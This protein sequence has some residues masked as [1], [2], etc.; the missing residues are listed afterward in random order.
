MLLF[1]LVGNH[2]LFVCLLNTSFQGYLNTM[3]GLKE[4][5]V[6][7]ILHGSVYCLWLFMKLCDK[8]K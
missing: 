3:L 2:G 7:G 8:S 6:H 4:Y 5:K 1:N